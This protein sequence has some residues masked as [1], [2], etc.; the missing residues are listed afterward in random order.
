MHDVPEFF[1]CVFFACF[2]H[3]NIQKRQSAKCILNADEMSMLSMDSKY[4]VSRVVEL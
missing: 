3:Y 1:V 2:L 4:C